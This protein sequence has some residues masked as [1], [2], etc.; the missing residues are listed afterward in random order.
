MSALLIKPEFLM[1]AYWPSSFCVFMERD[2]T[3][4]GLVQFPAEGTSSFSIIMNLL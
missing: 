1:T 3:A 4:H 2:V